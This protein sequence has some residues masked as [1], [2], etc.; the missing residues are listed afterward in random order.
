MPSEMRSFSTSTSSTTALTLSPLRWRLSASSPVTPQA[1]SDMWTMPS[2]SPSRPMNRPNSVAFLTSP[3]TSVPTGCFSAKAAQG[4]AC[5]CLRPSEMRRFSSSTSST[6]TSTS[7]E[8]ETILPGWTFFLVQLISE[9]W[10]RPSMPGSSSTKAPYSVMLVTRPLNTPPTGYLAAAPSHGIALE[11]LHAEADALGVAVDADDLHL[12]RVADVDHL[13]RV[14]DALVAD[15]G[16]VEQAVDAAEI[17]ERAVIGDVLDD[18]VDDLAF[19]ERLDQARALLGAGLFED[20]AARDDDIAAAA[21]HLQDLEGLRQVHQRADVADR[22]DVDLA[23]GQEGDGAAEIDGEAALDAAEDH[24]LDAV[25][26][27][28]LGLELVPGGFA[29]GA[30]AAAA[31]PRRACSRSGRHRPRPRRRPRARPSGPARRTR[32]AARGLRISGRR[33]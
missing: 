27:V 10:T 29:A 8:V 26:G 18:A 30:V 28:V 17:D 32:A 15:V 4:L 14:A 1:M 13:A 24:A 11:L 19:G 22:A 3:S 25:A 12:H 7:C 23:A 5:A 6:A 33:R 20:G 16:D 9:T 2:T 21:V 31:S